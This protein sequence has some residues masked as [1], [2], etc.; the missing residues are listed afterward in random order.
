MGCG[1]AE[2]GARGLVA[3]GLAGVTTKWYVQY[4]L[5]FYLFIFINHPMGGT[6]ICL[7]VVMVWVRLI[8]KIPES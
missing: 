4:P 2:T 7:L 8:V 6:T 3:K 5:I 1:F